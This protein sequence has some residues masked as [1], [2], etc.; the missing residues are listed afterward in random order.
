MDNI[1]GIP[2]TIENLVYIIL[3]MIPISLLLVFVYKSVKKLVSKLRKRKTGLQPD[4]YDTTA[5]PEGEAVTPSP[6]IKPDG[7][8]KRNYKRFSNLLKDWKEKRSIKKEAERLIKSEKKR[9]KEDAKKLAELETRQKINDEI[10]RTE[11]EIFASNQKRILNKIE[12]DAENMRIFEEERLKAE[13]RKRLREEA[14]LKKE[15]ERKKKIEKEMEKPFDFL[16]IGKRIHETNQQYISKNMLAD[17]IMYT[18]VPVGHIKAIVD[19]GGKLVK[20]LMNVPG[21]CFEKNWHIV[22]VEPDNKHLLKEFENKLDPTETISIRKLGIP[23]INKVL[24]YPFS[25]DTFIKTNSDGTW[26]VKKRESVMVKQTYFTALYFMVFSVTT[27]DS[28]RVNIACQFQLEVV[29]PYY[30]YYGVTIPGRWI[31]KFHSIVFSVFNEFSLKKKLVDLK[32][33]IAKA[34]TKSKIG[35]MLQKDPDMNLELEKNTGQVIKN[36]DIMPLAWDKTD[37]MFVA[38]ENVSIAEQKKL[39]LKIELEGKREQIEVNAEEI[40]KNK[41]AEAAGD[42]ELL[43]TEQGF[44]EKISKIKGGKEII[45]AHYLSKME[46]LLSYNKGGDKSDLTLIKNV[47]DAKNGKKKSGKKTTVPTPPV[48]P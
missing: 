26:D 37:P 42:K 39:A 12:T 5:V 13:E 25:W 9:L 2:L 48:T 32:I 33:D 27:E 46:N 45:E 8:I 14:L 44:I 6:T 38:L 43:L 17:D 40:E 3:L 19:P 20:F 7:F 31:N 28:Y 36:F 21:K 23:G 41:K 1:W 24:E 29:N 30:Q 16:G 10:A 4:Y 34:D 15:E 22:D 35:K 11:A 18:S 47:D